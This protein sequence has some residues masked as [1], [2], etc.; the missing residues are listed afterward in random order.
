[1]GRR[2]GGRGLIPNISIPEGSDAQKANGLLESSA[3]R[4]GGSRILQLDCLRGIAIAFVVLFHRFYFNPGP[5]YI[6]APVEGAYVPVLELSER[7]SQ[8]IMRSS[9]SAK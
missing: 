2:A 8:E 5:D 1:M 7:F 9:I 6:S 4:T 3:D